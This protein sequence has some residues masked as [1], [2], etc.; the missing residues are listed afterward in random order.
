MLR[1]YGESFDTSMRAGEL[2]R[3]W[4]SCVSNVSSA[5]VSSYFVAVPGQCV[6]ACSSSACGAISPRSARQTLVTTLQAKT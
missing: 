6:R 4:L 3:V 1:Y 2:Q 5:C